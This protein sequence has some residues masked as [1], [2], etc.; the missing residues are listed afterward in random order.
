MH[1][2]GSL[3]LSFVVKSNTTTNDHRHCKSVPYRIYWLQT[4]FMSPSHPWNFLLVTWQT[5]NLEFVYL[6]KVLIPNLKIVVH[7]ALHNTRTRTGVLK[8]SFEWT[9]TT[10]KPPPQ[11]NVHATYTC[12]W[13]NRHYHITNFFYT[14]LRSF[15]SIP[16]HWITWDFTNFTTLPLSTSRSNLYFGINTK[17]SSTYL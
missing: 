10:S 16:V 11:L 9:N 17:E 5:L 15:P 1:C 6:I 4:N 12:S 8:F 3:P 14:L 13:S 7:S 2:E